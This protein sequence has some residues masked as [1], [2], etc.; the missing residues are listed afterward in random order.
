MWGGV[1]GGGWRRKKKKNVL[2]TLR[3]AVT[4]RDK[5]AAVKE[6]F[7]F[8]KFDWIAPGQVTCET[9]LC[10]SAHGKAMLARHVHTPF[11]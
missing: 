3:K 7:H 2:H 5:R 1:G 4:K 6:K 9:F 11:D 8:S 10:A